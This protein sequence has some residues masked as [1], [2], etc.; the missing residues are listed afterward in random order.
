MYERCRRPHVVLHQPIL[1]HSWC[2]DQLSS[3]VNFHLGMFVASQ[4]VVKFPLEYCSVIRAPQPAA[5]QL[6]PSSVNS[7]NLG[8]DRVLIP[9]TCP[10]RCL[11]VG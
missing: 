10:Q 9:W 1:R 7:S 6:G 11:S 8:P 3:A 2:R 4:A 5:S